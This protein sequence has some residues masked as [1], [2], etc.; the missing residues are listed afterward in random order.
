MLTASAEGSDEMSEAVGRLGAMTEIAQFAMAEAEGSVP[1][2]IDVD[3][4]ADL[5]GPALLYL[6]FDEADSG[7]AEDKADFLEMLAE[8]WPAGWKAEL[9]RPG[10]SRC[11]IV[12][13]IG[14][15]LHEVLRRD[16]RD[17]L[18]GCVGEA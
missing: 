5:I 3:G 15:L 2:H 6:M 17:V 4:P 16:R 10:C 13:A 9:F 1:F 18:R 12:T 7:S 14:F 11:N 8:R